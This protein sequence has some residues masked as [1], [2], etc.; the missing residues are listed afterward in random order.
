LESSPAFLGFGNIQ[1]W[2]YFNILASLNF[3]FGKYPEKKKGG[4]FVSFFFRGV[5][6]MGVGGNV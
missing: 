4:G 6:I 1:A 2:Q 3:L 5:L